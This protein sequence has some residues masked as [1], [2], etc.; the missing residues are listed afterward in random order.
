MASAP[1]TINAPSRL[2]EVAWEVAEL[3]PRQGEWTEHAYLKLPAKRLVELVDGCLEFPPLP[4]FT[5]QRILLLIFM[6]MES[7][8]QSRPGSRAIAAAFK[9]KLNSRNYREPDVLFLKPENVHRGNNDFW[10]YADLVV[11]I[12]SPDDPDRDYIAKRT[13]YASINVPEYWIIDP[14][15]N[16]VLQLILRDGAYVD[17]ATV[18]LNAKLASV[19]LEGFEVDFAEL[20][21]RVG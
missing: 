8:S 9:L 15:K 16:Q 19:T 3:L 14:A 5:H 20:M 4:T 7:Y 12:V 1:N 2:G 17:H 10:T 18:A 11:E 6:L 21:S 13:A